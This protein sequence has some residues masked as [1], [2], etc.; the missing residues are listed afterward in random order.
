MYTAQVDSSRPKQLLPVAADGTV[1]WS[2][3]PS[4]LPADGNVSLVS[5]A[6][7][8]S[9]TELQQFRPPFKAPLSPESYPS[10]IP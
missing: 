3:S 7:D 8:W 6:S 5:V 9:T 2:P 4:D 1:T 10:P